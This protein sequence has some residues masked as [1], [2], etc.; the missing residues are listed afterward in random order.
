MFHMNAN[1]T[2]SER[3]EPTSLYGPAS[4][5]LLAPLHQSMQARASDIAAF[6]QQH[7]GQEA[8]LSDILRKM[9]SEPE[10]ERF[11]AWQT[12]NLLD[13]ASPELT[14]ERHRSEA[15]RLG[16]LYTQ[17][18]LPQIGLM[19]EQEILHRA[20]EHNIDAREHAQA[21]AILSQRLMCSLAWQAEA[22]QKVHTQRQS[23]LQEIIRLV[24]ETDN[25]ADLIAQAAAILVR[26]DGLTGCSFAKPDAQGIFHYEYI[27]GTPQTKQCLMEIDA[28]SDMPDAY[29]EGEH[30]HG[31]MG[32][33]WFSTRTE[34]SLNVDLDP[35]MRRW[36]PFFTRH[37]DFRSIVAIPLCRADDTPI[38]VL[39]LYGKYPGGLVSA[40]QKAFIEQLRTLLLFACTQL[41]KLSG[42]IPGMSYNARQRW[43]MLIHQGQG[44][45]MRYQP[46]I[47]LPSGVAVG[48]YALAHLQDGDQDLPPSTVQPLL[49]SDEFFTFYS[50]GIH[51]AMADRESWRR[52]GLGDRRLGINLRYRALGDP[53]Y[54]REIQAA[55]ARHDCPAQLLTL[56]I[57][58]LPE[59]SEE[60]DA[61]AAQTLAQI[62]NMGINITADDLGAGH[63][64]LDRLRQLP[65]NTIKIDRSIVSQ[66]D[67]DPT[68]VLFFIHRLTRLGHT[69]G[70]LVLVEGV[71]SADMLEAAAILEADAVQGRAVCPP[72]SAEQMTQWLKEAPALALAAH[73]HPRS[74]LAKLASLLLWEER[75]H[76]TLE[77]AAGTPADAASTQTL[78]P[79]LPFLAARSHQRQLFMAAR[80]HGLHSDA[81]RAA[82]RH[83][84]AQ[85]FREEALIS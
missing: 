27:A 34:C 59:P 84:I 2:V 78:G 23:L 24:W 68:N 38:S 43:A 77:K 6:F 69:L 36:Q 41:H 26:H 49:S 73:H 75:L 13:L 29:C 21:M 35:L 11:K 74:K 19:R 76:L 17:L 66:V 15:L 44:L 71:D 18:G 51:Q 10:L 39:C 53:R 16:H 54:L 37:A 67:K 3:H 33:A 55:M 1:G 83:F 31:M 79:A 20:V 56:H 8:M 28:Q 64:S 9:L 50:L 22:Y 48:I 63:S 7:V 45:R 85:L 32:R 62:K 81:Y 47:S 70:K 4:A 30:G 65:F 14:P 46:V 5:A 40:D 52:A 61:A 57:L 25:Y 12:G 80:D 60:L 58:D 72:L 82:R 42:P